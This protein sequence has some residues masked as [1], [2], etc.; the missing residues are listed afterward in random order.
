M[1]AI[2]SI[3]VL[4]SVRGNV[5]V[6]VPES[7]LR[8]FD[9]AMQIHQVF[10]ED[11][12]APYGRPL[13]R[14]AVEAGA[15]TIGQ[16]TYLEQKAIA[17][18]Y[19]PMMYEEVLGAC[20]DYSA[21]SWAKT[22]DY[23]S[24]DGVGVGEFVG[25]DPTYFPMVDVFY[26][27][28]SIPVAQ[29]VIGYQYTQ[30]ELRTSAYLKQPLTDSLQVQAVLGYKRH[31]NYVAL[32]GDTRKGFTGLYNNTSATAANRKSGAVW[33]SATADTI[34]N[35]CV[36]MYGKYVAG[37]ANNEKPSIFIVPISTHALMLQPR[38]TNS[39]TTIKEFLEEVLE[40]K[41]IQDIILDSVANDGTA[42]GS[43]ATKRCVMAAPKNDNAVFHVPMPITF[44]PPQ[45]QGI[46]VLVPAEYKLG[47]FE[48]R[49][50]Q[51]VRYMDGV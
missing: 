4:D 15:F 50:I 40:I 5:T 39:D 9:R 34:V 35:D 47:G 24:I 11:S 36:D 29:A 27:K 17:R 18:W 23:L 6:K 3:K 31:S 49:R 46:R 10:P 20:I 43:G 25:P 16:L 13:A 8:V 44:L 22:V 32:L 28:A 48:L 19:D 38:S 2:R 7:R 12:G 33:D 42:P 21:G 1:S 37:T 30:E 51:T 41:I 45:F 14:D 26:E